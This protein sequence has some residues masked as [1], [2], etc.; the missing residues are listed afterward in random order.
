[1]SCYNVKRLTVDHVVQQVERLPA[2]YKLK[3]H[4]GDLRKACMIRTWICLSIDNP[5]SIE[6]MAMRIRNNKSMKI[7]S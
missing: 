6:T 5:I 2:N 7:L 4:Y 1:M 3:I